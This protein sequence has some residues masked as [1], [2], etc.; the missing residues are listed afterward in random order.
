MHMFLKT[1][2]VHFRLPSLVERAHIPRESI[3][4]RL[5][6]SPLIPPVFPTP[7]RPSLAL[8]LPLSSATWIYPPHSYFLMGATP[9]SVPCTVYHP[10]RRVEWSK[11][12]RSGMERCGHPPLMNVILRRGERN[13][14]ACLPS[15]VPL[16]PFLPPTHSLPAPD[17]IPPALFTP[18]PSSLL[19]QLPPRQPTSPSFL[20]SGSYVS[21]KSTHNYKTFNLNVKLKRNG[22]SSITPSPTSKAVY[23]NMCTIPNNDSLLAGV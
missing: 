21:P 15:L 20:Y 5:L 19:Y 13:T 14:A 6:A 11:P 8:P 16:H 7:H 17:S 12:E 22:F 18:L 4:A 2:Y 3:S 9:S 10:L 23:L 1:A